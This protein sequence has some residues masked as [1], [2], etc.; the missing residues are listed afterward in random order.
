MTRRHRQRRIFGFPAPQKTA[1]ACSGPGLST[2][3]LDLKAPLQRS[4][5]ALT[6]NSAAIPSACSRANRFVQFPPRF[7]DSETDQVLL[8]E[9]V[10]RIVG[11]FGDSINCVT[12]IRSAERIFRLSGQVVAQ[13]SKYTIQQ[14]ES[15]H[16]SPDGALWASV[17]HACIPNCTI[18]F[19]TWELVSRSPIR[20][21]EEISFNYNSTEWEISS[22]FNCACGSPNCGQ[23]IRGFRYL[24]GAQRGDL[25]ALLSPYL[26]SLFFTTDQPS[27]V[28]SPY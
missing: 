20:V 27:R 3:F 6:G 11:P 7:V 2:G 17:N 21:G 25:R 4:Q 16:L 18:D 22:P 12:D 13:P 1:I 28:A 5:F 15:E 14:W 26:R 24:D 8:T 10:K 23:V 9:K 19:E